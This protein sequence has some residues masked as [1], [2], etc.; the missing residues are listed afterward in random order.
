MPF[1]F[2]SLG[3]KTSFFVPHSVSAFVFAR[4]PIEIYGNREYDTIVAKQMCL[5]TLFVP[6]HYIM[7]AVKIQE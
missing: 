4:Y 6:V 3:Y 1:D 7:L 2:V 5:I